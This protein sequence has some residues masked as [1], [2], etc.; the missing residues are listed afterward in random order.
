MEHQQPYGLIF[1]GSLVFVFDGERHA[2]ADFEDMDC[3]VFGD[4]DFIMENSVQEWP[5]GEGEYET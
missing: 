4:H 3:R 2:V 1:I 5:S